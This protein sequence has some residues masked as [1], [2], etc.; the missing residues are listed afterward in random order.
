MTSPLAS[1]VS[2]VQAILE[3]WK[4]TRPARA[5]TRYSQV[6]GALLCG[7]I[8]YS[9][10]FSLFAGLTIGYTAFMTVLGSNSELRES[11]LTSIDK[12]LPGLITINGQEG[13]IDPDS[14]VMDA[15]LNAASI[16]AVV[17]LLVSAISCMGAIR[18]SVRVMF[19]LP[20]GGG[21]AILAKLRDL[22]GFVTVGLA[23]VVSAALGI[24]LNSALGWVLSLVGI[25]DT[26]TVLLPLAGAVV[27]FAIDMGTFAV[28]VLLL[29][30]ARPPRRDLWQGAA[31]AAVGFG[32][33]RFLGTS[34][35]ARGAD[36][37]PI[38][39]SFAVIVTLLI[40]INISARILLTAA[41]F[42]AN[43]P[44]ELLEREADEKVALAEIIAAR[45]GRPLDLDPAEAPPV[46]DDGRAA[47]SAARRAA[48][49]AAALLAGFLLGRRR[50]P[51]TTP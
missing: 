9:A 48:T 7:G 1:L 51:R 42:T 17:V 25:E 49:L 16:I 4:G 3:W 47:P 28:V 31:L 23:L 37:N 36:A 40:W 30:G 35:V 6:N 13:L 27:S 34:V 12:A 45:E 15:S 33:V 24:V 10:I 14:L 8:A 41:A 21:N 29:A 20:P 32:V 46:P 22:A 44:Q 39:A 38:V 43:L 19:G 5:L 50:T 26:S 2:R 18:S 11:L